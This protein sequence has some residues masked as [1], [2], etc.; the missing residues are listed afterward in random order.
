[1]RFGTWNV[2]S[3]FRSGSLKT[4]VSELAKYKM[5]LEVRWEMG[6]S[7][8]AEIFLSLCGKGNSKHQLGT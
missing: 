1:M 8:P 6:S 5:E 7:E 3:L 2:R 4:A